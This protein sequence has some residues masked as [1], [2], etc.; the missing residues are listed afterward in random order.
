MNV[1]F[2]L[3]GIDYFFCVQLS[4]T[5]QFIPKRWGKKGAI[6]EITVVNSAL[7]EK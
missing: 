1:W 6:G 7:K 3:R 5:Q 2:Q 4:A